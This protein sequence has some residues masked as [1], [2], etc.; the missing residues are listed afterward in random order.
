MKKLI[1][2]VITL[3]VFVVYCSPAI[4]QGETPDSIKYWKKSGVFSLN[5]AQ[6]YFN[7]WAA[8]GQQSIAL[9]GLV[10]LT[11]NYKKDKS[12]WDN[13]FDF[14][15]GK[16]IQG[17]GNK[18]L[19][20]DDKINI[21]SKYGYQA[22]KYWYYT[23][24][25]NFKTQFDNGYNYP[26]DSVKISGFLAPAYALFA[27]GMDYKPNDNFSLF[28]T[29]ATIRTT[30]V[31]DKNLS[32]L[33]AFGVDP[34]KKA[35]NE[36]GAYLNMQ[37]KKDEIVKNVNLLTKIDLFSNYLKDPQNVDVSWE[38]LFV[39]KVNKF[40]SA[41]VAAN[42]LYDDNTKIPRDTNNDGII[43]KTGSV[44]QFKE[45]IGVGFTYKFAK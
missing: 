17:K 4:S 7:N 35:R 28:I 19:K 42:L 11:A 12:A 22:S 9:S 38:T 23:A 15:Y 20:T 31:N 37:Y 2:L 3:S 33:G 6:S 30:I 5:A 16:M 45:V 18:W 8:G 39:L 1:Y 25:F 36:V 10:N 26:N 21:T 44:T 24:L 29:P 34:G 32:D 27:L 14:G 40:I 43:D 41:T 13:T